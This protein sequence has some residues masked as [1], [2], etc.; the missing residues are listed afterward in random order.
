MMAVGN[1]IRG[2]WRPGARRALAILAGTAVAVAAS[3][4]GG[5]A[6]AGMANAVREGIVEPACP[7]RLATVGLPARQWLEVT[8]ADGLRA[9]VTA[10]ALPP[11]IAVGQLPDGIE[12]SG[13]PTMAGEFRFSV[14]LTSIYD[15]S[16]SSTANCIMEVVPRPSVRRIDA[17]DRYAEA[18]AIA[19]EVAPATSDLVYLVSGEGF[20]DALSVSAIAAQRRA[21]LLLTRPDSI[22]DTVRA[23][24]ERLQ[25]A[26]LVIVGG[27]RSVSTDVEREL[28]SLPSKP[29][30]HRVGGADRFAV[31]A[32]LLLHP[33]FGL[34][35]P[36]TSTRLYLSSGLVFPDALS[37]TPAAAV[38]QTGVLLI[39]GTT[40]R[41]EP[42]AR[43]VLDQL[44]ISEVKILGGEK[45][46]SLDLA[47]DLDRR[48][49]VV[50]RIGGV[51][52]YWVSRRVNK[53]S[54]P[55]VIPRSDA[56]IATGE[57]FPD[58]LAGGVLA[59]LRSS[60]L[61]LAPQHCLLRADA[62][63]LGVLGLDTITLFG[64]RATL[65]DDV[66]A[67]TICP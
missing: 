45:T 44:M 53:A 1:G 57:T 47:F 60:P 49:D 32:S 27:A 46:V 41:L 6:P 2:P 26:D 52:R 21:P 28:A 34:P 35:R 54:F 48:Y 51:D 38:N 23:E 8:G 31:S 13:V 10:G 66:E 18:V 7:Y 15:T 56:Y 22:P 58:A 55:S 14:T 62:E 16:A 39:D 40:S 11:G 33:E 67:L 17:V 65:T 5:A 50:Q 12:Y 37:A 64:G 29:R 19:R 42:E 3:V 61:V 4:V 30:V 25:P 24:L 20:A 43:A 63:Y 59:G 36:S 9:S